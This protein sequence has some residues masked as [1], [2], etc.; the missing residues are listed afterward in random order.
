MGVTEGTKFIEECRCRATREI[1]FMDK[2]MCGE[3]EFMDVG[4]WVHGKV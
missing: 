3:N 1:G 2:C 4:C